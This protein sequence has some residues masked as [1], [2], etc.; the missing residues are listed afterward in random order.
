MILIKQISELN[1]RIQGMEPGERST[2]LDQRNALTHQLAQYI[3]FNTY[4]D[5]NDSLK[6]TLANGLELVSADNIAS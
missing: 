3:N 6:L 4:T 5:A 2:L 1:T